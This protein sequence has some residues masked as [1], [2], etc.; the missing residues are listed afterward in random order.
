MILKTILSDGDKD[1]IRALYQSNNCIL[2]TTFPIRVGFVQIDQWTHLLISVTALGILIFVV[3]LYICMQ[4]H[5]ILIANIKVNSRTLL[6]NA[7]LTE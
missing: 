5:E 1:K 6:S 2:T 4:R 3:G 7:I